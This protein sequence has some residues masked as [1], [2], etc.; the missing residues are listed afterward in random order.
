M[1]YPWPG[2]D[3]YA[4]PYLFVI[5]IIFIGGGVL[6]VLEERTITGPIEATIL[7]KIDM[8]GSRRGI[9]NPPDLVLFETVDGERYRAR[10]SGEVGDTHCVILRRGI[11]TE[12]TTAE[13]E[14]PDACWAN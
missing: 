3:D 13:R 11:L 8:P 10:F 9:G 2:S 4:P 6:T 14:P 1:R 5:V 12:F 7:E